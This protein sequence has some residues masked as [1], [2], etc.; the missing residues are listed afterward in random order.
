MR[1]QLGTMIIETIEQWDVPDIYAVSLFVYDEDDDPR[2]P[3]VTLGYNTESVMK[4]NWKKLQ[5][6]L[7]KYWLT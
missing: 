2:K 1:E 5:K 3:T 7:W 6:H 4:K